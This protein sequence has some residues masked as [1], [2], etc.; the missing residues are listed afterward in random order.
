MKLDGIETE[1]MK[2]YVECARKH[3]AVSRMISAENP[4]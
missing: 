4:K 2:I 1:V 3:G